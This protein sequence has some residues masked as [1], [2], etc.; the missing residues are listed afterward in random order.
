M[1]DEIQC[2]FERYEKKY[3]LTPVQQKYLLDQMG[4]YVRADEYGEYTICNIYY[5]T[6]DWRLVR[7]SIEK[8]VY[9]EKLR[10]RSYGVPGPDGE[11]FVEL[12]KK[13]DG[14]V[15]KRRIITEA[16]E[17]EPFLRGLEPGSRFGQIGREIAWFQ[18]FYQT[19]PKVFIAYDRT[20][21]AG[22]D[23]PR[24]RITFDTNLRWRDTDLDLRLGDYG[25]PLL[26]GETVLMEVKMP[27]A[28]P[29]WLSRLLSRSG[30]F[31]ITFSKYG[32]CYQEHILKNKMCKPNKEVTDCA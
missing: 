29:L 14:V 12:K 24:L 30:T 25:Q 3:F 27:G 28:C 23:D 19:T 10:V 20:A 9:K 13:Y 11:I 15:Y 32:A 18:R 4:P 22:T 5:D 7:E 8:P 21:F 16:Y 2:C 6:D 26:S 31:P 17:A 1:A